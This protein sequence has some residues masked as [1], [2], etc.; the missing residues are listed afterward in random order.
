MTK[1]IKE[2]CIYRKFGKFEP[3]D[4]TH[5]AS[6]LTEYLVNSV[7]YHPELQKT[8][9][10]VQYGP[11]GNVQQETVFEYN[12]QGFLISEILKEAD[13]NVVERK[14][15]EPDEELRIKKEY[16]HYAD[17]SYDVIEYHYD[18]SGLLVKKVQSDN[19]GA[20]EHFVEYEYDKGQVISEVS[21]DEDGD[22]VSQILY[23][24]DDDGLLD[25]KIIQNSG[26]NEKLTHSYVYNDEGHREAIYSY[27]GTGELIEKF[28]FT[29]DDKGRTVGV[30]EE[31][32][33]K[34]NRISI[35]YDERDH[36]IGQEEYDLRGELVSKVRRYYD[37]DG[38]F[39]RSEVTAKNPINGINQHYDV[40]HIYKFFD[41]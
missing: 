25:E 1:R 38:L 35:E 22:M 40:M 8:I 16:I 5:A 6:S 15:Y 3:N 28:K 21:F 23:E 32:K 7:E 20:V 18:G 26:E 17:G 10:D 2:M 41:E 37:Q 4:L 14:T 12:A 34:K 13:G 24:Y 29:L 36:L 39:Q 31:N 33:Q 11:D 9:R 19:E 30:I 27:D